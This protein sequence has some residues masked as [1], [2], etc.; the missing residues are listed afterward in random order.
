MLTNYHDIQFDALVNGSRNKQENIKAH[1]DCL[2]K[3][4]ELWITSS[5]NN[6]HLIHFDQKLDFYFSYLRPNLS[7]TPNNSILTQ[8]VEHCLT[9][10]LHFLYTVNTLAGGLFNMVWPKGHYPSLHKPFTHLTQFVY[11]IVTVNGG[12]QVA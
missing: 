1:S 6:Q 11:S 9:A 5:V 3:I 7:L 12:Q 8:G 10:R 2:S 4:R